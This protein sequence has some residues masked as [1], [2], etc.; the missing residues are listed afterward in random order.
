MSSYRCVA[1][2]CPMAGST[3]PPE[4][5][6]ALEMNCSVCHGPLRLIGQVALEPT[7]RQIVET[8]PVLIARPWLELVRQ[9]DVV[10]RTR[11]FLDVLTNVLKYLALLLQSEYLHSD[12]RDPSLNRFVERDLGRP[13]LSSWHRFVV[14]ALA[15]FDRAGHRCF[16]EPLP[17][18]YEQV[19]LCVPRRERIDPPGVY[20]D[21]FG[22]EVPRKGGGLGRISAL[23]NYRNRLAHDAL[24]PDAVLQE[25]LDFYLPILRDLLDR[26]AWCADYP[27]YKL[28]NGVV[29]SLMGTGSPRS[30]P[31]ADLP[32]EALAGGLALASPE[33]DRFLGLVPLMIV[34]SEHIPDAADLDLLVYD[35]NTGKRIVYLSPEGLRRETTRT[36]RDWRRLV[37]A[38]RIVQPQLDGSTCTAAE[39]ARRCASVTT[40]TREGLRASGR[41]LPG[42]W[43]P[44]QRAEPWFD[45]WLDSRAP[46]MA[47]VGE[48]GGGK[49][50]LLD[51]R[52]GHWS[53]AGRTVLF[54]RAAAFEGAELEAALRARLRLAPQLSVAAAAARA[55][56]PLVV[57]L[58]GLD[59]H[60][61]PA[62][63][64]DSV[65]RLGQEARE[66]G[67]EPALRIL[68]S[69][70]SEQLKRLGLAGA[71]IRELLFQ[72][73]TDRVEQGEIPAL[74]LPPLSHE[75]LQGLWDSYAKR[76]PS[77][78]RPEFTLE[79]LRRRGRT[80]VQHLR[81]P[82]LLRLFLEV[83]AGRRMPS[84]PGLTGLFDDWLDRMAERT[85]DGGAFLLEL[86][87]V[88]LEHG[89]TSV[90]LDA[91]F[92][93]PRIGEQLRSTAIDAP[94]RRLLR[95]GVLAETWQGTTCSVEFAI[96]AT[97][98]QLGG[99][100]LVS[101]G[102]ADTPEQLVQELRRRS[103]DELLRGV[104][105]AALA[106]Q[107]DR[108]GLAFLCDFVDEEGEEAVAVAAPVLARRVL[109]SEDPGL[110]ADALA[111]RPTDNDLRVAAAAARLMHDELRPETRLAF[112]SRVAERLGDQAPTSGSWADLLE[113]LGVALMDAGRP[114]DSLRQ[115]E[116]ALA[117]RRELPLDVVA[118]ARN[119]D[120]TG[121]ACQVLER[122]GEALAH[123]REALAL[124]RGDEV[125]AK[126]EWA[127]ARSLGLCLLRDW[128]HDEA[129]EQLREALRLARQTA[130]AGPLEVADVERSIG[131]ALSD[132]GRYG[133]AL[134]L[135]ASTLSRVE[136]NLGHDH[137]EVARELGTLAIVHADMGDP[138]AAVELLERALEIDRGARSSAMTIA[139]D[140][141]ALAGNL[142]EVSE[143]GDLERA[144]SLLTQAI[145]LNSEI[146]GPESLTTDSNRTILAVVLTRQGR[147]GEA[148]TLLEDLLCR[149]KA[150]AEEDDMGLAALHSHLGRVLIQ[151]RQNTEAWIHL[152][153]ALD[154]EIARLG[155][156]HP[157]VAGSRVVLA[158][159]LVEHGYVDAAAEHVDAALEV[160]RRRLPP[161]HPALSQT[162]T[163]LTLI[164]LHRGDTDEAARTLRAADDIDRQ[165][166]GGP[167]PFAALRT[168]QFELVR[169]VSRWLPIGK[170]VDLA[171]LLLSG[172]ALSSLYATERLQWAWPFVVLAWLGAGA[173][174]WVG[175]TL[176]LRL[177]AK[178]L[179]NRALD[180]ATGWLFPP[181]SSF[182]DPAPPDAEGR[183]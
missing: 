151:Q 140:Y 11:T 8:Y 90:E 120:R 20:Y 58:D 181:T 86:G 160:Q 121:L 142:A 87:R 51:E 10:R 99:R 85:G 132:C 4:A 61:D 2:S 79:E 148:R 89:T 3:L 69:V 156:D 135:L 170:R 71:E 155:E 153:K 40:A 49:T 134:A 72:A 36:V 92:E 75:E 164:H 147:H 59:E 88:F 117:Q 91:L 158:H 119:L 21:D 66:S 125:A 98:E 115:V 152:D 176:L 80:L 13:L 100:V 33:H 41:I 106:R 143:L 46:L 165:N 110:L 60:P 178:R 167:G 43:V 175:T 114:R 35:Q 15:T 23:I 149:H 5:A 7:D 30:P 39:L 138:R 101:A 126:R 159:A 44:R 154:I 123:H 129:L 73:S 168:L 107:T 94:Y 150:R 65:L 14:A 76:D 163:V 109:R 25:S 52:A 19:E 183:G 96:G 174:C 47:V 17:A 116:A 145:E 83:Y 144:E 172:I 122:R 102:R 18:F 104:C 74:R 82:L 6:R 105:R 37:E 55:E 127:S 124:R 182:E 53:D 130:E 64:F 31:P 146:F 67:A 26:M 157:E 62:T 136:E 133:E 173:G 68:V 162:L 63:L 166:Y 56:G 78:F 141:H 177:G 131:L 169:Y 180:P 29:L 22:R 112:L 161:S 54:S 113:E 84:A 179:T 1:P 28:E 70:R 93:D 42:T 111:E 77:R 128:R 34:P 27:L 57:V 95:D 12:L 38:K 97:L 139:G 171:V 137:P 16:V 9:P 24:P 81:S 32:G 50:T 118:L 108:L 48:A 103:D 45:L